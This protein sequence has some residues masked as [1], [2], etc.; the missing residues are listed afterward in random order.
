VV[1]Q[2]PATLS[3]V[4]VGSAVTVVVKS[5]QARGTKR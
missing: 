2:T 4:E 1:A 5:A 3:L